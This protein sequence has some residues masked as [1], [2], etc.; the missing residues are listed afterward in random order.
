LA[1]N[2]MRDLT[3]LANEAFVHLVMFAFLQRVLNGGADIHREYGLQNKRCDIVVKY[4][5][6][7]YPLEIKIKDNQ[8]P[9]ESYEQLYGYM[10]IAGSP[11]GW[12]I[13]FDKDLKKSWDEKIFWK[14][15]DYRGKTIHEVGC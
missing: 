14:E 4:K 12:L 9:K 2:I 1:D 15:T 6:L 11:V 10:D 3:N 5:G 8:I 7:F 13:V